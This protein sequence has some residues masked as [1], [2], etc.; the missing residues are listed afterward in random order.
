MEFGLKNVD[1]TEGDIPLD[2]HVELF[3]TVLTE[4]KIPLLSIQMQNS[5][6]NEV[7][8]SHDSLNP[9]PAPLNSKPN[10]FWL[11]AESIRDAIISYLEDDTSELPNS[12]RDLD[13]NNCIAGNFWVRGALGTVTLAPDEQLGE[14][15]GLSRTREMPKVVPMLALTSSGSATNWRGK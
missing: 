4:A 7:E 9:F 11:A 5:S 13:T 6:S 12:I 15:L 14:G 10:G 2:F 3:E 1:D 8:L